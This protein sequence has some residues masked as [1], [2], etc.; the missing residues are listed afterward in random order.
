VIVLRK[1]GL[2]AL[3]IAAAVAVAAG[4]SSGGTSTDT[5]TLTAAGPPGPLEQTTITVAAVPT[6][7]STGLYVAEYEGYFA[8]AGLKVSI[9]PAISAEQSVN[10]LAL[11]KIDV[12]AG[13][14]VSF[15][16]AQINHDHGIQPM[17]VAQPTSS[18]I[19]AD[20]DL[21]AEASVENPGFVGLFTPPGS[22]IRTVADLR[23]K[24]IGIN[25]PGNVAYLLVASFFAANGL[26]PPPINS[27]LWRYQPFPVM[28]TALLKNHQM[29]VAFLAEP[30]IS[31]AEATAGLTPLTDLDSGATANF[32]IEGYAVTKQWARTHPNTLI[33]FKNA[34]ERGQQTAGTFRQIAE[35]ATEKFAFPPPF[36]PIDTVFTSV[37]TFENYPLGAVDP[38]RLQRVAD[39]M[40]QFGIIGSRFSVT[41][42]LGDQG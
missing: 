5:G 35:A 8:Q 24:T 22:P 25:A 18:Q 16:Q 13:N 7:D 1:P 21:F 32:P 29:D 28:Q 36:A 41:E 9:I 38:A 4:C 19:S 33:A 17:N 26:T 12:L 37:M 6:T 20:L 11:G 42:M 39:E 31:V 15:I 30:F 2:N 10:Q 3:I 23:G 27:K 34:L 40:R 14:Y